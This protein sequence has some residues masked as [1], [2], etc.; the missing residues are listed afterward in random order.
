MCTR[1]HDRIGAAGIAL[2]KAAGDFLPDLSVGG[3][4]AGE[5]VFRK[6]GELR[7]ANE[8]HIAARGKFTNQRACVLTI[9]GRL[10]A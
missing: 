3:R 6:A 4:L 2:N 8:V 7:R 9:D 1:K 10:R 5:L